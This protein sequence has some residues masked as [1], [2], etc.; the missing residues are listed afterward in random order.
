MNARIVV[1]YT[2]SNICNPE[3]LVDMD[4]TFGQMVRMLVTSEGLEG[5][6]EFE[7]IICVEEIS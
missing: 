5:M 6:A 7:K 3:D 2:A 4:M 1:T